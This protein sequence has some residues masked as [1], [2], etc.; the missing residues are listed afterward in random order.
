MNNL[1]LGVAESKP[2]VKE[3][4]VSNDPDKKATVNPTPEPAEVEHPIIKPV[5]AC[6]VCKNPGTLHCSRCLNVRYCSKTCQAANWSLHK[7]LCKSFS[8]LPDRPSPA[9]LRCIYFPE[10]GRRPEFV[11]ATPMD[12]DSTKD[13]F[14]GGSSIKPMNLAWT[15]PSHL[16]LGH[17]ITIVHKV[18]FVIDGSPPNRVLMSIIDDPRQTIWKDWMIGGPRMDI[19]RGPFLVYG[20]RDAKEKGEPAETVDLDT[21]GLKAALE[22]FRHGVRLPGVGCPRSVDV[23]PRG[24]LCC[25]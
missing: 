18:N 14:F 22:F 17:D 19:W 8:E 9:H 20:R 23:H 16:A 7:L 11:Y 6:F 24:C 3:K 5:P 10:T 2:A 1:T 4:P 13:E 15:I 12:L 21:S 25:S